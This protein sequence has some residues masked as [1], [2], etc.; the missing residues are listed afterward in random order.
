MTPAVKKRRD[1]LSAPEQRRS[2][3]L[4][5]ISPT[6]FPFLSRADPKVARVPIS[7]RHRPHLTPPQQP[8]C[9]KSDA[10]LFPQRFQ[11]SKPVEEDLSQQD[12]CGGVPPARRG[13]QGLRPHG[14]GHDGHRAEEVRT[15]GG[16]TT[17]QAEEALGLLCRRNCL[18]RNTM[19]IL[20]TPNKPAR[21]PRRCPGCRCGRRGSSVL[22]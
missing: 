8:W 22:V 14:G 20:L 4:R 6:R 13:E 19:H 9:S 2:V 12:P 7:R 21:R 5:P 16:T 10:L 1:R 15:G 17:T 11:R 3:S 18:T